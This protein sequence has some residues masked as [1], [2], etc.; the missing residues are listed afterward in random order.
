M[1][2]SLPF[3]RSRIGLKITSSM[4]KH[5]KETIISVDSDDLDSFI[6]EELGITYDF[7]RANERANDSSHRFYVTGEDTC[8]DSDVNDWMS[9]KDSEPMGYTV[10]HG[11]VSKGLIPPGLYVIDVCW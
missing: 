1:V 5:T 8:Y 4:L 3:R 10:L 6:E 11:L 9:G 2:V 7:A